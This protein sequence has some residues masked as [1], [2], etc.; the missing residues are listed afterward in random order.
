MVGGLCCKTREIP[1]RPK[2][3]PNLLNSYEM[4][5]IKIEIDQT[6]I[7]PEFAHV[8]HGRM[9]SLF[10]ISR[11]ALLESIGFP[12]SEY[13]R[14]GEIVVITEVSV[15]YKR[16]VR[17]GVVEVS[18]EGLKVVGRMMVLKQAIR[19]DRGKILAEGEF[20]MMFMHA[21]TRRGYEPPADLIAAMR[22]RLPEMPE[23]G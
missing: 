3:S 18:C 15:R 20:S 10:E 19:N 16:E 1:N 4:F 11:E 5:S 2:S 6:W 12:N 23:M 14:R 8:H 22:D 7:A 9:L 17:L 13:M 21:A